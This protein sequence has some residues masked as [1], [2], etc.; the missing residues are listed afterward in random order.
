MIS[1]ENGEFIKKIIQGERNAEYEEL[2]ILKPGVTW[3]PSG[4]EIAFAAKSGKSDALFIYNLKKNKSEKFRLGLEGIFRPSWSPLGDEIAFIGNNGEKSDIYI[5][6]IKEKK[7]INLTDDW[8]SED[9]VSWAPDGMEL[10][11][12]SDRDNNI[13]SSSPKNPNQLCN[14][15]CFEKYIQINRFSLE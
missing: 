5:Y 11:F 4:Q 9:H 2:H 15:T 7:L 14:F 8:Y 6:D 3:S 12:I 1:T 13:N 10:L